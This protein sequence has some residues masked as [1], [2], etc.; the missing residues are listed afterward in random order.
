MVERVVDLGGRGFVV[1]PGIVPVHKERF[2]IGDQLLLIC[3]DGVER[4]TA[5]AGIEA[6]VPNPNGEVVVLLKDIA[7]DEIPPG[8]QVWSTTPD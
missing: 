3:P 5:I 8:T 6:G 2:H 7:V 4:N 1:F